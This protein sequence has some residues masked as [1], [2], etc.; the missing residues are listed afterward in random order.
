[1]KTGKTTIPLMLFAISMIAI[2]CSTAKMQKQAATLL[3]ALAFTF[4]SKDE[5]IVKNAQK[6]SKKDFIKLSQEDG[7]QWISTRE[8]MPSGEL[9]KNDY[10]HLIR[11]QSPMSYF[12]E[13]GKIH[14]F[15]FN[16]ATGRIASNPYPFEYDEKECRLI[17]NNFATMQIVRLTN[18]EVGAVSLLGT[19]AEGK[20]TYA[21]TIYKRLSAAEV[22]TMKMK[23]GYAE[24]IQIIEKREEKE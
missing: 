17:I 18:D 24:P 6:I 13:D 5:C 16:S 10:Y 21:Y 4:N 20:P 15:F 22:Q 14:S 1:M 19:D 9:A 7:L 11:G 3:P 2:S 12:F 8:I 23:Y